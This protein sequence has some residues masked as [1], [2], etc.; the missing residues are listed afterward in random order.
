[1][2]RARSNRS[3]RLPLV[4]QTEV[5]MP[6]PHSNPPALPLDDVGG[7][8][9][10]GDGVVY[11]LGDRKL[12]VMVHKSAALERQLRSI[13]GLRIVDAE[14]GQTN[15][16]FPAIRLMEVRAICLAHRDPLRA[17]HAGPTVALR[18]GRLW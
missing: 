9:E 11:G 17:P 6:A 7:V 12:G 3:S 15:A 10:C 13:P 2:T 8:V 4:Q 16:I 14:P 1:M 5:S 18:R